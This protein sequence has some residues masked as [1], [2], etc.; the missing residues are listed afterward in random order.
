MY[1]RMRDFIEKHSLLY[2]SQYGFRQAH[3]TQ[4]AI[5]DM[6]E[7]I[8]TNMDKKLFSCG[9]F[10]DLKKAFDTVNHTILLD[11]L[12]YYG[13]RGIV[14]QWFSSYSSNRTQTTEIGS[15]ISSKLNINCGVPQASVLGP[16]LF[17]L[18]INDIQYCSSKLQVFLSADD[19]N[20][21]YAHKDLKT[22]ELTVNPELH[23]LYNWLTSNKLSLNIKKSKYVIFR[24]YQ[25]KITYDPWV[26][27]NESNKKVA[28]GRKNFIK[29]LGLFIDENLSWKSHIHSA[30]NKINKTIRLIA[31]L[32]HIV[33]TCTL[34]N[35]YQSLLIPYLTFG[36]ISLGNAGKTFLDQIL[37]L[38]KRAL[39]LIYFAET[40]GH[41]MKINFVQIAATWCSLVELGADCC[42]LVQIC[43]HLGGLVQFGADWCSLVQLA[44]ICCTL[45]QIG[46]PWCGLV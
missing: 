22:L 15:H 8:Q 35:I 23:N 30:A 25:K 29:Y 38:R 44:D 1:D 2:S 14:N 33:P 16:L 28:L 13:F 43:P 46:S 18:C 6:V 36:L 19:T 41:A 45:M 34:L 40:N 4:H 17:L 12:N 27:D 42:N 5:L 9:V 39:R 31:R 24:P 3:S 11:K 32:R 7:T 20:T 21:L 37:V 10:I 26:F